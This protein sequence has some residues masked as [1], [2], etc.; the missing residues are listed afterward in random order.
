V[1]KD[2]RQSAVP[3]YLG[4]VKDF[5]KD[6]D[7]AVVEIVADIQGNRLQQPPTMDFITPGNSDDLQIGEEMT[8][9]GYPGLGFDSVTVS[10]GRVS[11]FLPFENDPKKVQVIKTD[12]ELNPGNSGGTAINDE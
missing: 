2:P 9:I 10:T 1:T 4:K 8:I 3:M 12:A 5:D 6:L 7:L 11:G